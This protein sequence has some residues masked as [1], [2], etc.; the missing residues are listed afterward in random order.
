MASY[1]QGNK[2]TSSD[3][4]YSSE[5]ALKMVEMTAKGLEWNIN[6]VNKALAGFEKTDSS[7]E[8]SSGGEVLSDSIY[9]TGKLSVK[10]R[11]NPSSTFHCCLMSKTLPQS[12]QASATTTLIS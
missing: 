3:Q 9:T 8:R 7:C 6:L 4:N 1:G 2:V 10:P 11:V 12:P 5:K